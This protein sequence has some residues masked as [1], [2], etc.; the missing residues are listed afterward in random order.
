[1][2]QNIITFQNKKG[3]A[4]NIQ[5]TIGDGCPFNCSPYV[6]CLAGCKYCYTQGP[7]FSFHGEFGKEVKVKMWFPEQLDKELSKYK[8]APQH[9]KRI[10][11]NEACE[12]YHPD[13]LERMR[14]ETGRDLMGEILDVVRNHW[15]EGN[16]WMLHILTKSHHIL[17]HLD[18]IASMREMI[19]V[20]VTMICLDEERR[21][22]VEPND[23]TISDRLM[24][25]RRLSQAGVFVRVMDMPHYGDKGDAERLRDTVFGH[26]AKAFKHKALNYF[27]WQ[28]V[29]AGQP[30]RKKQR[31]DTIYRDLLVNSGELL[32]E[33][34]QPISTHLLMPKPEWAKRNWYGNLEETSVDKVKFGYSELNDVDWGYII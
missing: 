8:D 24:A 34:G 21:Q 28:D 18:K 14:Q 13:V 2:E 1:M 33:D 19:Q 9:L 30:L 17:R 12:Y 5:K 6:G 7:P 16:K 20:E 32:L 27:T 15:E 31:D 26:G 23:F 29:L 3:K 25:I 4:L 22:S 10:Q 11:I